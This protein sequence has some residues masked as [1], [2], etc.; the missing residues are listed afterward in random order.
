MGAVKV[1]ADA[2]VIIVPG[3]LAGKELFRRVLK[4]LAEKMPK[5]LREIV[6]KA[7]VEEIREFIPYNKGRILEN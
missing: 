7:S 1:K 2:Y 6:A 4:V 5:E 3:D